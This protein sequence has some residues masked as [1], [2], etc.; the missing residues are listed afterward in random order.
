MTHH[1]LLYSSQ[2]SVDVTPPEAATVSVFIVQKCWFDG[3][4]FRPSMD[5]P[6]V[7]VH[8]SVAEQVASQSAH[9]YS[10]HEPVRTI[11]N[12]NEYSFA[13]RG[14]LF[15]VRSAEAL[16]ADLV[17]SSSSEALAAY[18]MVRQ[19]IIGGTG[20]PNSRRGSEHK[21]GCIVLATAE[22]KAMDLLRPVAISP[23]THLQRLPIVHHKQ[24]DTSTGLLLQTWPDA[25]LWAFDSQDAGRKREL[26]DH[27][28]VDSLLGAVSDQYSK[29]RAM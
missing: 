11:R 16:V 7:F 9:V 28:S 24:I 5:L 25:H 29:K 12:G 13:T 18:C 6:I 21:Q 14:S 4:Q 22:S 20:N 15:W 26:L 27:E 3:P 10:Q 17:E 8:L 2:T 19:Y 1:A 23:L